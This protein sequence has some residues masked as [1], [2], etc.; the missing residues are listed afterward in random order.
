MIRVRFFGTIRLKLKEGS[1]LLESNRVDKLLI[2][3]SNKYEAIDQAELKNS[4][5]FV[6]DKNIQHL[7]LFK[8]PL[9][10]GDEVLILSPAGG[11]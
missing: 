6:N 11:G 9:Q 4:V 7:K 1:T 8:T 5:I 3:I 10:D 2:A